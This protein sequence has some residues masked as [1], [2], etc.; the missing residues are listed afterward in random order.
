MSSST[1]TSSS[2]SSSAKSHA[3]PDPITSLVHV[4]ENCCTVPVNRTHTA[5]YCTCTLGFGI[6]WSL[7]RDPFFTCSV[8]ELWT[9]PRMPC[10]RYRQR[11]LSLWCSQ[12]TPGLSHQLS[13][14]WSLCLLFTLFCFLTLFVPGFQQWICPV[15]AVCWSPE[16]LSVSDL[17]WD[18]LLNYNKT[19]PSAANVFTVQ[20]FLNRTSLVLFCGE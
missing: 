12:H 7:S 20:S 11:F 3:H 19:S 4:H 18:R 14:L 2:A 17:V 13:G 1:S 15:H 5:T 16:L 8:P 6:T 9:G 10:G